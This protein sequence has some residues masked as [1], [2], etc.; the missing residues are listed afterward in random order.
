MEQYDSRQERTEL[1]QAAGEAGRKTPAGIKWILLILLF[2]AAFGGLGIGG[3]LLFGT[4]R[5]AAENM[6]ALP[7]RD[8]DEQAEP[9]NIKP[10][11]K[12]F[13]SLMKKPSA[14]V[15]FQGTGAG[16]DGEMLAIIS[17]ETV[18][19]GA[20]LHG[21]KVLEIT[22]QSVRLEFN[23]QEYQLAPGEQLKP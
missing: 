2:A 8:K 3:Y 23:G 9:E 21:V 19:T 18:A 20:E 6:P 12:T 11:E 5:T 16:K 15:V 13:L 7:S 4:V 14:A 10:P 1:Q 22:R 17:G